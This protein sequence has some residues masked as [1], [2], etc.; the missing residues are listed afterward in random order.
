MILLFQ[1]ALR[2]GCIVAKMKY[3]KQNDTVLGDGV[4]SNNFVFFILSGRCQMIESMQVS[5]VKRLGREF[6]QLYDP[7][8]SIHPG[9][10]T[11]FIAFQ[12]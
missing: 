11:L 12:N 8:V 9:M 10:N 6:Y 4:S 2:E 1:V 7:F 3:Y 5:V